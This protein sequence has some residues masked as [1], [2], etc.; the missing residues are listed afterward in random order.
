M[1]QKYI[2]KDTINFKC[3]PSQLNYMLYNNTN[4][5]LQQTKN[6]IIP[7]YSVCEDVL[8]YTKLLIKLEDN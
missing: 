3:A 5:W 2:F 6:Y 1:I 8:V 4:Q 7:T